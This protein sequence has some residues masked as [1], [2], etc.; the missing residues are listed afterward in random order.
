VLLVPDPPSLRRQPLSGINRWQ[1]P[2]DGRLLTLSVP[3]VNVEQYENTEFAYPPSV[4]L[5]KN[6]LQLKRRAVPASIRDVD[7]PEYRSL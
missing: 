3:I 5:R 7:R 1:Q 2:Y 4:V 6:L